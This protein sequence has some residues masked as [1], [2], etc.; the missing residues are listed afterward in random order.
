M[1]LWKLVNNIMNMYWLVLL[2]ILMVWNVGK[3]ST[4]DFSNLIVIKCSGN[5]MIERG[6]RPSLVYSSAELQSI[7][8]QCTVKSKHRRLTP[9][10]D[11]IWRIKSWKINKRKI[12]L[13]K[14][15]RLKQKH[16]RLKQ[17]KINL[18][19][20]LELQQQDADIGASP[21][22]F[23]IGTV[24]ARLVKNK[25]TDIISHIIQDSISILLVTETWFKSGLRHK[26][27]QVLVT[28]LMR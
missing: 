28:K 8:D 12:Q 4:V 19:N 7:G 11:A 20:I 10:Y 5:S 23:R 16:E 17:W 3:R 18:N 24:N 9:D 26:T 27:G 2:I 6:Q 15:E 21:H 1:R 25:I 13:Q 14:H 22:S